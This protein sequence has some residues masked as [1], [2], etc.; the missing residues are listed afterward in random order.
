MVGMPAFLLLASGLGL[1]LGLASGL[2]FGHCDRAARMT[3]Q[4]ARSL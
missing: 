1:S 4:Y 3:R 2:L